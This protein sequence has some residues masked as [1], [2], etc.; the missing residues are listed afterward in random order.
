[1]ASPSP[2]STRVRID[3]RAASQR[4]YP[5]RPLV[6]Q[7]SPCHSPPQSLPLPLSPS[8]ST[9]TGWPWSS[10]PNLSSAAVTSR[11]A[12]HHN[13][14]HGTKPGKRSRSKR[15]YHIPRAVEISRREPGPPPPAPSP[16][17][18][19]SGPAGRRVGGFAFL[20]NASFNKVSL[21]SFAGS[22]GKYISLCSA[23]PAP[24]GEPERKSVYL[25]RPPGK[26]KSSSRRK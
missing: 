17:G 22:P 7:S 14:P 9:A 20:G 4:A 1:M 5:Y 3:C 15:R 18:A 26:R 10:P 24:C 21:D 2:F 25:R 12:E 8:S 11:P 16:S 6:T 19:R 23:A 13:P